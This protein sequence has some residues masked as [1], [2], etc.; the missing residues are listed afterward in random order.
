MFKYTKFLSAGKKTEERFKEL[1]LKSNILT[2]NSSEEEDIHDHVDLNIVYKIDV[3]GVKKIR[4]HDTEPNENF[5]YVEIKNVNG[6]TGWAWAT[7]VDFFVF[8]T[9]NY[10]IVVEK[11]QLQELIKQKVI[12]EFMPTPT[13]YK[14]YQREGRKDIITLVET[15]DLI[16]IAECMLKK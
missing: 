1:L 8:E 5:H 4:R 14:L 16:Y 7:E 15:I 11:E 13:A 9:N 3:K 12:K 10:W 2:T 6:Q